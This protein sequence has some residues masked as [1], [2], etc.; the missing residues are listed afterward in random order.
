MRVR[1]RTHG[2]SLLLPQVFFPRSP[3]LLCFTR[4]I[5]APFPRISFLR[6]LAH[7]A[8]NLHYFFALRPPWPSA[9]PTYYWPAST[10]CHPLFCDVCPFLPCICLSHALSRFASLAFLAS[11]A[12][13]SFLVPYLLLCFSIARSLP[14]PYPLASLTSLTFFVPCA[15]CPLGCS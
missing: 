7:A 13:S 12:S 2:P 3:F 9:L 15:P 1:V 10:F 8:S 5:I 11:L 6:T 4:S 14:C